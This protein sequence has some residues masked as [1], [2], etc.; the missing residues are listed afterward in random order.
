MAFLTL[1]AHIECI[2]LTRE[3][4]MFANQM[5][6]DFFLIGNFPYSWT[7]CGIRI[8]PLSDPSPAY[9]RTSNSLE[10]GVNKRWNAFQ[11][12]NYNKYT[13]KQIMYSNVGSRIF[14]QFKN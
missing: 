13:V 8:Q 3:R 10:K 12:K 7:I 2:N 11:R 4:E 14:P 9:V 6:Q 1:E 5:I